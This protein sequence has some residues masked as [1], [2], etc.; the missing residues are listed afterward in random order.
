[1]PRDY[2]KTWRRASFRGAEFWVETDKV[3]TGRSLVVHE[4]PHRDTPYVEDM[5]RIANKIE[6]TAYVASDN[7][8]AEAAALMRACGAGGAA[9]LVLPME[10]HKVH[11]ETCARD[12]ARDRQGFIA[13][14]LSFVKDGSSAAPFSAPYLARL[15]A[16]SAFAIAGP[17]QARFAHLFA[18]AGK[19]GYVASAAI[20]TIRDAAAALS[21]VRAT[22]PLGA[23]KNAKL[24]KA[25]EN[26][27]AGAAA[28]A[29]VGPVTDT[30]QPDRFLAA[31]DKGPAPDF[32][33]DVINILETMRTASSPET[34]VREVLPLLALGSPPDPQA[35]YAT[36]ARRDVAANTAAIESCVRV[37]ALAQ[38]AAAVADTN[39]TDRRQAI[40]LRA[41]VSERFDDELAFLAGP[42]ASGVF[43]ALSDVRSQAVQY[44]TRALADLKPVIVAE[45]GVPLPSLAWSHHLYGTADRAG[46]LVKRNRA[47][48]ASFMPLAIEAV[49]P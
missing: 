5:G 7:A 11:C 28:Y 49:A 22:L 30:W 34:F 18:T 29:S 48:H 24:V 21:A 39:L 42:A 15:V 23:D 3:E 37:L 8:P 35:Q 40:G 26:L 9:T 19:A 25:I 32:A 20:S 4:F 2:L 33:A 27:D 10:R 47:I 17:V 46:E 41:A 36:P 38:W 31:P 43:V 13:F 14:A 12:W 45:S 16:T 1:M 6:V 44:L